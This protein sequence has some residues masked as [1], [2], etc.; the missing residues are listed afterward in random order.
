MKL[1][2]KLDFFSSEGVTTLA[3]YPTVCV[4]FGTDE[5]KLKSRDKAH[6]RE[7]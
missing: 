3:I 4:G 1:K 2:G 6:A 7:A 5:T